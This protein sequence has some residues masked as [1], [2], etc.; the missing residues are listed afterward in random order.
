MVRA[1]EELKRLRRKVKAEGKGSKNTKHG[2][3]YT[4]TLY[5]HDFNS[6]E[7]SEQDCEDKEGAE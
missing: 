5:L 7:G 1:S 4:R 3:G 2:G 6:E